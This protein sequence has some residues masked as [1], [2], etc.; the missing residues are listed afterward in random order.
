MLLRPDSA[1][2]R[3]DD[4][5]HADRAVTAVVVGWMSVGV[6]ELYAQVSV[7][8]VAGSLGGRQGDV[9]ES[10][11][12]VVQLEVCGQL[13]RG[14]RGAQGPE[15]HLGDLAQGERQRGIGHAGDPSEVPRSRAC[16]PLAT[17]A[18]VVS[19]WST[20]RLAESS[21]VESVEVAGAR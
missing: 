15:S 13:C 5:G 2:E 3:D 20:L 17:S 18:S 21:A 12:E 10:D 11:A 14:R 9:D 8:S 7:V 1:T 19:I 4:P 6:M 16:V